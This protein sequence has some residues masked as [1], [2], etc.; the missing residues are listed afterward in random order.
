MILDHFNANDTF[1]ITYP[2]V[3]P[4]SEERLLMQGR[5]DLA[6]KIPPDLSEKIRKGDTADIQVIAD[7]TMSNM[8]SVRIAYAA[9]VLNKVNE[10]LFSNSTRRGWITGRSTPGSEHRQIRTLTAATFMCRESSHS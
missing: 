3:R 1:K 5:I 6:I 8:A 4:K 7:G 2:A 10:D 9:L